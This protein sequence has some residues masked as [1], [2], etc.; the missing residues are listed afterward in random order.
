MKEKITRE[1]VVRSIIGLINEHREGCVSEDS[2]LGRIHIG[3]S[4]VSWMYDWLKE[5]YEWAGMTMPSD[6]EIKALRQ[7]DTVGKL[8]DIAM[9]H[10]KADA[11]REIEDPHEGKLTKTV[12]ISMASP[13][14]GI[15]AHRDPVA[16]TRDEFLKACGEF[17]DNR[18]TH[19]DDFE[20]MQ[21]KISAE[22][23]K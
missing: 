13:E 11:E 17:Y 14:D 5:E 15:G 4:T 20:V 22:G 10:C 23:A 19:C 21:V 7:G 12:E 8:A 3:R 9:S 18:G 16:M 2:Q 6:D 1:M